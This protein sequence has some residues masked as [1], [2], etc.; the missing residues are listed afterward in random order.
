[1]EILTI[2]ALIIS[3][4]V[5]IWGWIYTSNAQ[6][7]ILA[8]T[9]KSQNLDRELAVFRERLNVIRGI[10]ATLIDLTEPYSQLYALINSG[11]FTMDTGSAALQSGGTS[12]QDL[13]K[14]LYDPAFRSMLEMLPDSNC[15]AVYA[16]MENMRRMISEFHASALGLYPSN[17]DFGAKLAVLSSGAF[18]VV[19]ELKSTAELLANEFAFLDKSLASGE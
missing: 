18:S 2:I 15:D 5:T 16:K 12:A 4:T 8:A 13:Y 17:P 3:T 11:Q 1:M 14:I 6:R 19:H 10:N 9:R 7:K